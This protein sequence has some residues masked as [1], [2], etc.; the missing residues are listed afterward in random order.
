MTIERLTEEIDILKGQINAYKA[1]SDSQTSRI[2]MIV[3]VVFPEVEEY[4]YSEVVRNIPV[5]VD[6]LPG[7]IQIRKDTIPTVLVKWEDGDMGS[8]DR[9]RLVRL[10]EIE[11]GKDNLELI[12]Y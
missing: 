1:G 11:L 4:S 10:L 8:G 3:S 9:K 7:D 6:S 12:A 2:A 5:K